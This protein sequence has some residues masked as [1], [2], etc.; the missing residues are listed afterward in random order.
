[1]PRQER[2]NRCRIYLIPLSSKNLALHPY[3]ALIPFLTPRQQSHQTHPLLNIHATNDSS[4]LFT[5]V[6][7]LT[8]YVTVTGFPDSADMDSIVVGI[9]S[10]V[11]AMVPSLLSA[12]ALSVSTVLFREVAPFPV[13]DVIVIGDVFSPSLGELENGIGESRHVLELRLVIL[14]V[15]SMLIPVP[16]TELVTSTLLL[17]LDSDANVASPE[18]VKGVMKDDA[19]VVGPDQKLGTVGDGIDDTH[20]ELVLASSVAAVLDRAE[21]AT[22][23]AVSLV[24]GPGDEGR[25]KEEGRSNDEG[26]LIGVGMLNVEGRLSGVDKLIGVGMLNDE[27]RLSDAGRLIG[28]GMLNDKGR[29]NDVT[30]SGVDMA[31]ASDGT[32]VPTIVDSLNGIIME[33]LKLETL[34][35][36]AMVAKLC[37]LAAGMDSLT[38]EEEMLLIE[39]TTAVLLG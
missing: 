38:I 18:L 30:G 5:T 25:S 11:L 7:E 6:D 35:E 14:M 39:T 27:G 22:M 12:E 10:A 16:M 34:D 8:I 29:L 19:L 26:R 24:V 28:V 4:F 3:R 9:I 1:M 20:V 21:F 17:M 2:T 36:G 13:A 37:S 33:L 15:M 32:V 23:L 31:S